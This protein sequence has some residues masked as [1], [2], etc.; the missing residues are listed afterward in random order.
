M[1]VTVKESYVLFLFLEKF[2]TAHNKRKFVRPRPC[3]CGWA[4]LWRE[5][6]SEFSSLSSALANPHT[7]PYTVLH[8]LAYYRIFFITVLCRRFKLSWQLHFHLGIQ[9]L[10]CQFGISLLI[11]AA[12]EESAMQSTHHV[13]C[14]SESCFSNNPQ[15]LCESWSS[16]LEK[17]SK[18]EIRF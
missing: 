1:L 2:S 17:Y 9:W 14:H 6:D 7:T 5:Q 15:P 13:I 4:E 8:L 16:S 18:F 11:G 3:V 10:V 12:K